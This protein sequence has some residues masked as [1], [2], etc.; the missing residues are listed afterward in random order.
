MRRE[1]IANTGIA[2]AAGV[3]TSALATAAAKKYDF[4]FRGW[5]LF[6]FTKLVA[7]DFSKPG[8]MQKAIEADRAK[9]PA[10]PP[11]SLLKKLEFREDVQA[12]MTIFHAKKKGAPSSPLKLM[13]LHGG[14]FVLDFQ[15]IQWNLVDGLLS[16]LDA[17]V[18]APIYPLGPEATWRETMSAIKGFYLQLVQSH[19]AD[20]IVVCGDS[21]GGSLSL[22]L[23]QAIRDEQ[24]PQPSALVLFS[25]CLDLSAS[26]EDQPALERRDPALCLPMLHEV[27]RL[28]ARGVSADDPR[29]SA[30]FASQD[31]LPPTM[32]FSG[33]R[34]ILDSDA[35]RLKAINPEIDHR[36]YREMMHVWPVSP[37]KE[38]RQAL[39]EAAEFISKNSGAGS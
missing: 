17:D 37:L 34:E 12:G 1:S 20:N 10:R 3:G 5:A 35:L 28:W 22:L 25:P 32:V 26:G 33:D 21:A 13:Y 6:Q 2:A 24:G 19:G 39:D 31:S 29:V 18:I 9:G 38:A 30:L 7:P 8:A 14:A 27:A 36:H 15:A 16:R 11:K 4:N 23:A